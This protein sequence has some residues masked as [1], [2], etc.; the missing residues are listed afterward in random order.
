[1]LITSC[2]SDK[3]YVGDDCILIMRTI[4]GTCLTSIANLSKDCIKSI[5]QLE[6]RSDLRPLWLAKLAFSVEQ[7][8]S[9]AKLVHEMECLR[10]SDHDPVYFAMFKYCTECIQTI[11]ADS[12]IQVNTYGYMLRL[13]MLTKY[14]V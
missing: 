14:Q 13:L 6:N 8:I 4:F 3:Y 10:E 1:M 9:F 2:V 7:T 5:H 12:K 11:L